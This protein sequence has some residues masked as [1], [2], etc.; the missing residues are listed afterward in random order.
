MFN[1]KIIKNELL[2]KGLGKNN[3]LSINKSVKH[4]LD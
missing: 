1:R 4:K 3:N 2:I